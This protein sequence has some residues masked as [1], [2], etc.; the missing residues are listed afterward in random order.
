MADYWDTPLGAIEIQTNGKPTAPI[1]IRHPNTGSALCGGVYD[2]VPIGG[3]VA[4]DPDLHVRC[5]ALWRAA[6]KSA[7]YAPGRGEVG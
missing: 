1:H 3:V 2:L 5:V 7:G 6:R 4:E